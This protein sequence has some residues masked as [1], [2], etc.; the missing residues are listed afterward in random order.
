MKK[1]LLSLILIIGICSTTVF[2]QRKTKQ[3]AI[4][5]KT[6]TIALAA[7]INSIKASSVYSI[8]VSQ[9]DESSVLVDMPERYKDVF[10]VA[11]NNGILTLTH[12][13]NNDITL[14][15]NEKVTATVVCPNLN[16]VELSG[17]TDLTTLSPF[18]CS[19][20]TFQIDLSGAANFRAE[21]PIK[22][23]NNANFSSS[24]ASDLKG[25]FTVAG[26]AQI[27]ASGA[28]D[29]IG[30]LTVN[31]KLEIILSGASDMKVYGSTK[32]IDLSTSG[33]SDFIGS[34]F[35]AE[36]AAISA[37][38]SSDIKIKVSKSLEAQASGSSD[39]TYYG[40][41]TVKKSHT[42]RASDINKN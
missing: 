15:P 24:G 23:K 7:P 37:T 11:I 29:F 20:S 32:N 38:G 18:T 30:K 42:S 26:S 40:N 39:I 36:N 33:S 1:F 6:H 31:E 27:N 34:E 19:S 25:E 28:S 17:A 10:K 9:G 16:S 8:R 5:G 14:R 22:I 12:K 13:T 35:T 2:A 41:P 4:S 3:T 21:A